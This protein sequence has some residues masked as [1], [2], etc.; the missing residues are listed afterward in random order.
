MATTLVATVQPQYGRVRLELTFT[1]VTSASII[2]IHADGTGW[3]VRGVASALVAST[4]GVGAVLWDHEAP[5]D[6]PVSYQAFS[7]QVPTVIT[8]NTVTVPSDRS[9]LGSTA[10][11][12]HPMQPALSQLV[13]V[14]SAGARSRKGRASILPIAGSTDPV[15]ITDRRLPPTGEIVVHTSTLAEAAAMEALL[16][17]GAVLCIRCPAAWGSWW[18]YAALGDTTDE[19]AVGHA[20]D[21]SVDWRLPYTSVARPTGYPDG[22]TGITYA[23]LLD[24]YGTYAELKIGDDYLN[25]NVH[26]ETNV[27][28]WTT[29]GGAAIAHDTTFAHKGTGS[30]LVTP[31]GVTSGP[32]TFSNEFPAVAGSSYVANGWVRVSSGGSASRAVGIAWYNAAHSFLSSDNVTLTPSPTVWTQFSGT[33][34]APANTAFAKALTAGPG[35]LAAANTWRVDELSVTTPSTYYSLLLGP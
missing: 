25:A 26:F 20:A 3:P 10:W 30:M 6:Q 18:F 28:N 34:T 5:L 17:D 12:T 27:A 11:L 22:P 1:T 23:D 24:Q 19:S 15:A 14:T 7:D 4:T 35:V 8:S 31:D 21:P 33:F 16:A 9:W 32:T 13:A 2:R 29:S